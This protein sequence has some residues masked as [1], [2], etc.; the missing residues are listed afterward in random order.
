MTMQYPLSGFRFALLA[1]LLYLPAA[2][3]FPPGPDG[4]IYGMARD[5]Y[6]TPLMN[7]A[8]KVVLITSS[9]VRVS[10]TITPGLAAGINYA[11]QVP[12]DMGNTP[13]PYVTNAL[14]A[15]TP[16]KLYIAV[17][18]TTNLPIEMVSFTPSLGLPAQQTRQDL[19][20]GVDSNGNGIPDAWEKMFFASLGTN[21]SL[22][23]VNVNADYAHHGRTLKQEYLLGN[24]PMDPDDTFN[25]KM[26]S[27]NGGSALLQFVAVLGRSYTIGGSDNLTTWTNLYFTIPSEGTNPPALPSYYATDVRTMQVQVIQPSSGPQMKFFRLQLQ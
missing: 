23:N 26:V 21:V 12:M 16:Y 22:T 1:V 2:Q 19:T 17:G 7:A 10:A 3:A 9:G 5:Q 6:G 15:A 24:Y 20:L 13:D 4:L 14:I 27:L 18:S 8:D 25:V 11:L